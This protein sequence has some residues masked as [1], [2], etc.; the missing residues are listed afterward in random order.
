[1]DKDA[2]E[3]RR[4]K[5]NWDFGFLTFCMIIAVIALDYSNTHQLAH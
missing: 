3:K 2:Q 5:Y 4:K 1:M